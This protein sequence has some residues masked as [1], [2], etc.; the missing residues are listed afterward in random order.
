M[1]VFAEAMN[2]IFR[3]VK[4][5]YKTSFSIE[6]M[7]ITL[8]PAGSPAKSSIDGL[9]AVKEMGLGAM[10]LSFTHGVRMGNETA[11][12][13]GAENEKTKLRLSIH[14]PYYINLCSDDPAKRNA[15]KK[16]IIDTCERGH[17]MGAE[18]IIF[19]PAYYGKMDKEEVFEVVKEAVMEMRN[20]LKENAWDVELAPETSGRLSQF[21]SLEETLRLAKEAK[22]NFC[23]DIAHIYARNL[24][25]VD[26]DVIFYALKKTGKK[27]IHFH[28]ECI[29]FG[30][31]GEKHHLVLAE[32]K[33]DF[34]EFAAALLDQKQDAVIISESPIT[35]QDS[36]KMKEILEEMGYSF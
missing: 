14:A 9:K 27:E 6:I 11:K 1:T 32:K 23:V 18:K 10:E 29:E 3:H 25:T 33:P 20:V 26:Y 12:Q 16:R 31:R 13:I 19:H 8:G 21:G 5:N 4:Q 22:T 30:P 34:R 15:S 35:W 7:K 28:F 24:G 2:N 17:H 36:L